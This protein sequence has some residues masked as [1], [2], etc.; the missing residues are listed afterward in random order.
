MSKA[1]TLKK[2]NQASLPRLQLNS[3]F[4]I[5][6]QALK[7]FLARQTGNSAPDIPHSRKPA[8]Q[9][10]PK[11]AV[12]PPIP[13]KPNSCLFPQSFPRVQGCKSILVGRS[14]ALPGTRIATFKQKPGWQRGKG[15]ESSFSSSDFLQT[16]HQGRLSLGAQDFPSPWAEG[17]SSL[18]S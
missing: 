7:A 14:T 18:P 9:P 4:S 15:L 2:D 1:A 5:T 17:D 12:R 13:R 11:P 16:A 3:H 8:P 10:L 6:R